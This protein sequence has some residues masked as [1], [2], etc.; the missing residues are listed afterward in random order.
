MISE[1]KLCK[2]FLAIYVDIK[3][4]F[5]S[6]LTFD[7]LIKYIENSPFHCSALAELNA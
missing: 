6:S 1:E 5:F 7:R 3:L 2:F 4:V